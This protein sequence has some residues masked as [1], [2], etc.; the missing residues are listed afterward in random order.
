VSENGGARHYTAIGTLALNELAV[1][2][3]TKRGHPIPQFSPRHNLEKGGSV[4]GA[5]LGEKIKQ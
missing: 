4:S 2:F 5:F 1:T 3:G